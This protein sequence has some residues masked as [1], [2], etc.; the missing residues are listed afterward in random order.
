MRANASGACEVRKAAFV[1]AVFG[2]FGNVARRVWRVAK[3][4]YQD[5]LFAKKMST[6]NILMVS[7]TSTSGFKYVIHDSR[8]KAKKKPWSVH[9]R[10][11]RSRGFARAIDAAHHLAEILE[12]PTVVIPSA[13]PCYQKSMG[14]HWGSDHDAQSTLE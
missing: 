1:F 2:C 11:Y 7:K 8:S 4:I 14:A 10:G 5:C 3:T 6:T 12:T 13:I 9:Y